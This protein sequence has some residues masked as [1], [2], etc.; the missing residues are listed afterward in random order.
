MQLTERQRIDSSKYQ[1]YVRGVERPVLMQ[2]MTYSDK[3]INDF[4][5]LAQ[6]QG[7]TKTMRQLGYPNSWGTA[8]RWADLRGVEVA[9]DEI[10]Q[11]A[12]ATREWYKDEELITI[13]QEGLNRVYEDLTRKEDLSADDQRKLSSAFSTYV[14]DILTIQGRS[15]QISENRNTDALDAHLQEL[16]FSEVEKNKSKAKEDKGSIS[17]QLMSPEKS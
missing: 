15:T 14:K 7:I 13:A 5:E 6:D 10:R 1:I 2:K 3:E 11:K 12:V 8:Q 16:L 17:E 9:V 4:L